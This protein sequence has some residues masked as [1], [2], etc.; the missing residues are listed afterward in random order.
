MK[1]SNLLK[2]KKKNILK[3]GSLHENIEINDKNL[4]EIIRNK[5]I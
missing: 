1:L 5:N 3:A 2:V 4:D